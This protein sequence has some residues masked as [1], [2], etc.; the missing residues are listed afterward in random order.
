M[1]NNVLKIVLWGMTVG[2]LYWNKEH[3]RAY[4]TYDR[5]LSWQAMWTT[6]SRTSPL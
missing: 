2:R 1:E 3:R 5:N 4:F 6:T